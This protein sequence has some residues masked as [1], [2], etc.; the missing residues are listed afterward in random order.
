MSFSER[1]KIIIEKDYKTQS[2]FA[3]A[4]RVTKA[5]V[6]DY[7]S[8]KRKPN[9]DVLKKI[10]ELGY[11]MNW[12]LTGEGTEKKEYLNLELFDIYDNSLLESI[13]IKAGGIIT[14]NEKLNKS[15][16][17]PTALCNYVLDYLYFYN[18]IES[19]LR[20]I[21]LNR[22]FISIKN[23]LNLNYD[24]DKI[25]FNKFMPAIDT[26]LKYERPYNDKEFLSQINDL[27]EGDD[28]EFALSLSTIYVVYSEIIEL[29]KRMKEYGISELNSVKDIYIQI[30]DLMRNR[31]YLMVK[32][33]KF[34]NVVAKTFN[35]NYS[36]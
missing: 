23:M 10:A 24:A 28:L 33:S 15:R 5:S 9:F 30:Y 27:D 8:S 22:D 6:N 17:T 14:V 3:E 25:I 16:R 12:L 32:A 35:I 19:L 20:E 29:D 26:Y 13:V 7:L 21:T 36:L 1:L 31:N 11:N 2:N 4:I 18:I 34:N